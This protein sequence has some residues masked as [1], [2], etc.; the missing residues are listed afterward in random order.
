LLVEGVKF[1]SIIA[2]TAVGLSLIFATTRLINF[3]HDELVTLGA[4][5]AFLLNASV[6]GPQLQLIPAVLVT[7]AFGAAFGGLLE[8]GLWKPLRRQGVGRG[9]PSSRSPKL[10]AQPRKPLSSS[11]IPVAVVSGRF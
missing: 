3:A 4:T 5:V 1:G 10:T 2:I 9:L 6:I 8:L 7:V 11:L